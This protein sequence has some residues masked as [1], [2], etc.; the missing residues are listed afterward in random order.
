MKYKVQCYYLGQVFYFEC[1]ARDY[2]EAK[3]LALIQNP[4]ATVLSV[5]AVFQ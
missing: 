2:A 5:T 1:V 3:K 4:N